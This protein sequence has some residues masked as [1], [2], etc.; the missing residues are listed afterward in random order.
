M[1]LIFSKEEIGATSKHTVCKVMSVV[2]AGETGEEGHETQWQGCDSREGAGE[3][4][5]PDEQKLKGGEGAKPCVL[6]ACRLHTSDL[7]SS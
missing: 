3:A 2:S 1:N 7:T 5:A 4:Q 6:S